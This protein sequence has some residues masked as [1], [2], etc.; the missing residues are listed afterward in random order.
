M[1]GSKTQSSG[2]ETRNLTSGL[3]QPLF[4]SLQLSFELLVLNCQS[5]V[6]V[7]KESLKVLNAL[8]SG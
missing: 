1:E 7:L 2:G 6:G 3:V 5:A 8:V 4:D